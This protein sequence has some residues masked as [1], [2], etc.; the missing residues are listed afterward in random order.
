[1]DFFMEMQ[2]KLLVLVQLILHVMIKG[3]GLRPRPVFKC[4]Y[5]KSPMVILGFRRT[6]FKSG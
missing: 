6:V 2:K 4:P 5:C 3:I 1:M